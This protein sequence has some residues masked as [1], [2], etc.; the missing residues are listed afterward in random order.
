MDDTRVTSMSLRETSDTTQPLD[1]FLL[2]RILPNVTVSCFLI[3]TLWITL[4]LI[5][6]GLR[7]GKWRQL[8]KQNQA[9]K[10]NIG[11]IYSSIVLC[12]VMGLLFDLAALVYINTAYENDNYPADNLDNYCDIIADL[13]HTAYA[14]T[15]F[16]TA[17]FLWLRQRTFFRNR[18]L[19]VNYKKCVKV[20]SS[21][22]LFLILML[23]I[24]ALIFTIHPLDHRMTV[25][26]C[27]RTP[28]EKLKTGYWILIITAVVFYQGILWGLFVYAL[29]TTCTSV[30]NLGMSQKKL[31]CCKPGLKDAT[32]KKAKCENQICVTKTSCN[33]A[34]NFSAEQSMSE[35][36]QR[37]VR[38]TMRKTFAA[39]LTT[40]VVDILVVILLSFVAKPFAHCR[41]SVMLASFNVFLHLLLIALSFVDCKKMLAS[42]C[43]R[44]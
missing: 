14:C 44:S 15:L 3:L 7:T 9:D 43:L 17:M 34:D 32:D 26:G 11:Q 33:Q 28:H 6:Y 41:F 13:S 16:S 39:A 1:H 29:R 38:T 5:H 19:N 8:M 12:G 27:F 4:S 37:M 23:G 2:C 10:L 22:S 42:F 30:N 24:G 31:S 36:Q 35:R 18:L 25:N 21:L 40:T 20:L